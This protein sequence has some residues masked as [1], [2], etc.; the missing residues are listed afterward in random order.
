MPYG[1]WINLTEGVDGTRGTNSWLGTASWQLLPDNLIGY[2]FAIG[3]AFDD[4]IQASSPATAGCKAALAMT[5]WSSR[6]STI[7][8]GAAA[9]RT[10]PTFSFLT[11]PVWVNLGIPR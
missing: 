8:C 1:V 4:Y 7:T 5:R 10:P 11:R 9:E 3:S 6:G 2:S